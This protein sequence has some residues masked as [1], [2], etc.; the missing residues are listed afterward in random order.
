MAGDG[1]T[2]VLVGDARLAPQNVS[3]SQ[4]SLQFSQLAEAERDRIRAGNQ[5][6]QVIRVEPPSAESPRE[7][8]V[9]SNLRPFV[10]CPQIL[11][12]EGVSIAA[13]ELDAEETY[14]SGTIQVRVDVQ[15]DPRQRVFLLLNGTSR[16]NPDTYI[17][18]A[19][20][21][22]PL[23][24]QIDFPIQVVLPGEYLVRVQI[25]G[26]ESP[27]VVDEQSQYVG[28]RLVIA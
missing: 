11:P 20:R 17:F 24:R 26:A 14:Y 21:R 6:I 13:L 9:E 19:N 4:V 22:R 15:V 12:E 5:G 18:R 16:D 10:L 8:A 27:L 23:G 28:P 25:D 1:T 3:E 7:S 2:Y